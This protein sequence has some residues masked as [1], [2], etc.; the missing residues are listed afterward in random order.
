M[1]RVLRYSII[2]LGSAGCNQMKAAL[3]LNV[4]SVRPQLGILFKKKRER[5]KQNDLTHS[6]DG[7][8]TVFRNDS[9]HHPLFHSP[10][11]LRFPF[12]N[13]GT[14]VYCTCAQGDTENKI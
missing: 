1:I 7:G 4:N 11:T 6:A 12:L 14:R 2:W 10:S 9:R 3:E 13:T 5:E 8:V